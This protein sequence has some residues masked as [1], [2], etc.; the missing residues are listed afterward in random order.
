MPFHFQDQEFLEPPSASGRLI[1]NFPYGRKVPGVEDDAPRA[2]SLDHSIN[3]DVHADLLWS[4]LWEDEDQELEN[5]WHA[6]LFLE[7]EGVNIRL[8]S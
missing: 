3:Q 2:K 7:N 5:P 4:L 6:K 1:H 8:T